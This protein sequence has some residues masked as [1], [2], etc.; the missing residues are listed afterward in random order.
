MVFCAPHS[1]SL[2]LTP[3]QVSRGRALS[4]LLFA[5]YGHFLD[6]QTSE[7][8]VSFATANEHKKQA[9]LVQ[10]VFTRRPGWSHF[11]LTPHLYPAYLAGPGSPGV[12]QVHT[13][14]LPTPRPSPSSH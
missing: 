14:P 13:P 5:V 12:P 2:G 7:V 10:M 11:V 3:P 1:L 9:T 8:T 4:N 6:R